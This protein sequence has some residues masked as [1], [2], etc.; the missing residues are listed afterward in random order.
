VTLDHQLALPYDGLVIATGVEPRRLPTGHHLAGVHLLRGAGD[1][2]ALYTAFTGRPRV[3]VIGA[4]F[5]GM[6]VAASARSLGLDV[7]VVDPLATPMIRQLG[8]VVGQRVARL[9]QEHGVT[10]R[11]GVGVQDLRGE[12][13]RVTGVVLTTGEVLAAD[14]V[15]V[16]I[17]ASPTVEW[18]RASG[19]VLGD[20]IECDAYCQAAPGV[21]AAGDVASWPSRR[22]GRRI[23]LEHRL[24]A[25]EQGAAAAR[26]L[27]HGNQQ[28]FD[29]V[30]YFWSDQYDVKIQAYG[31][32]PA[33]G[34]FEVV[35]GAI[36]DARFVAVCREAGSV[37]GALGWNS[38]KQ[39]RPYYQQLLDSPALEGAR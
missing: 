21:Y 35:H 23:R 6:E 24:N 2:A 22:Y 29:P 25:G 17:G 16:A 26:N 11:T 36:D 18:L 3:V 12:G 4:G 10:V 38:P 33:G 32:F 13:D 37:V 20:G 39:V 7:T 9:H 28:P 15:L 1:A 19:L 5:L 31:V 14:C 34:R 30:P 8:T 27:L